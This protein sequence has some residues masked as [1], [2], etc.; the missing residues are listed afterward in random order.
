MGHEVI[1]SAMGTRGDFNPI[2]DLG[3]EFARRGFKVHVLVN[4]IFEQE[5]RDRGLEFHS[6]GTKESFEQ[7]YANPRI[8]DPKENAIELGY[9]N[10]YSVA[11]KLSLQIVETLYRKNKNLV[12]ISLSNFAN[13]ASMAAE[14]LNLPRVRIILSPNQIPSDIAPP[15]PLLWTVPGFFPNKVKQLLFKRIRLRNLEALA[16]LSYVQSV[17][18][19]RAKLEIDYWSNPVEANLTNDLLIALFPSWFAPPPSDTSGQII[20]TDFPVSKTIG[21]NFDTERILAFIDQ[22]GPPLVVTQGTGMRDNEDFFLTCETIAKKLGMPIVLIG[23]HNSSKPNTKD[24]TPSIFST[25]V[26][27]EKVLPRCKAIIHHGGIGTLV[28]ALKARIPQIIRPIAFDQFDNGDKL[29]KLGYGA[30]ILPR[31]F[32]PHYAIHCLHKLLITYNREK[33]GIP[34]MPESE[35]VYSQTTQL[36]IDRFKLTAK[37][38]KQEA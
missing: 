38:A 15:A 36:I 29:E 6:I 33:H 28:Q 22:Y 37:V 12:V 31:S 11:I 4:D 8:W 23:G 20:Y 32:S 34:P 9:S 7:Y 5:V 35:W 18:K 26:D 3:T 14:K 30:C 10:V 16:K 17:K 13:G 1:L 27:L 25:G 21:T 19:I 24:A 2:A